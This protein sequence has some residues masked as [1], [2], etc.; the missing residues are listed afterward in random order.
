MLNTLVGHKQAAIQNVSIEEIRES[1][2]EMPGTSLRESEQELQISRTSL[3]CSIMNI[4]ASMLQSLIDT[5]C[6]IATLVIVENQNH[7]QC[8]IANSGLDAS[9]DHYFSKMKLVKEVFDI[10][11]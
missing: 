1:V 10:S 3:Q 5:I 6:K 4:C 7:T 9:L 11:I 2:D 8:V